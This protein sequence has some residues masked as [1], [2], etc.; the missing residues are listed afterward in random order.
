MHRVKDTDPRSAA[1][2]MVRALGRVSGRILDTATGLGYTAIA[3]ARSAEMVTTVELDPG[4]QEIARQNPW[5]RELF[6]NP[7]IEQIMGDSAEII[8]E[9][10]DNSFDC[11]MHDPPT[12]SLAGDLYS[13]AFYREALRILKPSG[14][15]FHYVGDPATQSASRTTRGVTRRLADAGFTEIRPET[16]AH[17]I[18]ARRP[19]R[20]PA[21]R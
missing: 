21:C 20:T 19:A 3:M 2:A 6:G 17:G 15:L 12:L 16:A 8:G 7:R 1:M 9:L 10:P 13:G 4:A 5:S 14:R 11:I 18:C